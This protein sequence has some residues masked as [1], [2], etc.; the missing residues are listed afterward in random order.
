M[1][2][3]G[4]EEVGQLAAGVHTPAWSPDGKWIAF[5]LDRDAVSPLDFP[6]ALF[7]VRPDGTGLTPITDNPTGAASHPV[8]SPEGGLYYTMNGVGEDVDG[9]YFYDVALQE[10][11]L[12]IPSSGLFPNSLSPAGD[13]LTYMDSWGLKVFNLAYY[14]ILP[15]APT[16]DFAPARLIGWLSA[17]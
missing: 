10:H 4:L 8:W 11:T 1:I 7:L 6:T 16:F 2:E 5:G 9:I 3:S 17:E 15:V 13:Y 14:E 12:I